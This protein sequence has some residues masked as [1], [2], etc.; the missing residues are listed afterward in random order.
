M[1]YDEEERWLDNAANRRMKAYLQDEDTEPKK[2]DKFIARNK[3]WSSWEERDKW[4]SDAANGKLKANQIG[5]TEN[6]RW[7]G[8]ARNKKNWQFTPEQWHLW[9]EQA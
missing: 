4:Y 5:D 8:K 1:S 2:D 9:T 7:I 6:N 3:K